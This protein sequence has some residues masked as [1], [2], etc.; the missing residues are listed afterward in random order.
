MSPSRIAD[1]VGRV[2]G[3][4]YR[5]ITPIGTGAS[6]HVFLADDA[7]LGRRV[8]VKC[9]HAALAGDEVFLRRFRAEAQAAAALNHPHIMAVIDWGEDGDGP[10]LVLEHL[11]GGSLRD[12]LDAGHRLS[13][14]QATAVGLEA[15][16]GLAYA[17]R[18]GLVHRDIKPANLLFDEESRLCV[19]DFGLA[20]ALAEAAWTE[21]V[22][23]LMGTARYSS[24]EAAQGHPVDGRADLYALGLVLIE[25]VTGKV[26]FSADTT[27]ATLMARIGTP[28]PVPDAM[29]PLGPVVATMTR[30]E[31]AERPEAPTLVAALESVARALPPPEA[32]PLAPPGPRQSAGAQV[33]STDLGRPAPPLI[34]LPGRDPDLRPD[35]RLEAPPGNGAGARPD[36]GP[37][38]AVRR[39]PETSGPD[40]DPSVPGPP[41]TGRARRRRWPWVVVAAVAALVLA[42]GGV[43]GYQV[44][45][46]PSYRVPQLRGLALARAETVV[47]RAPYRFHLVSHGRQYDPTVVAGAVV[48]QSPLAGSQLRRG[49]AVQVVVSRGPAPRA[50]P[51]LASL[52]QTTA[53][54]RLTAAGFSYQLSPAYSETVASGKVMA[55]APDHGPQPRGTRVTVTISQGPRPRTVP[56][57]SGGDTYGQAASQLQGLGL[58]PLRQGVYSDTVSAG[59]VVTTSPGPGLTVPR[60][61]DVTVSVS[62]GPHL[63][64]MPNLYGHPGSQ[65]VSSLQAAGLRVH[66]YGPD[67]SGPVIFTDPQPGSTVHYGATVSIYVL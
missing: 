30:P 19:A 14:A 40:L 64:T 48:S 23:A 65:A 11:G 20:R 37:G 61:A 51:S 54:G 31:F 67:P 29:G 15:A 36:A 8:A 46:V 47:G 3:G 43:A 33:D 58:V 66:V 16:K 59:Q 28:A 50:V 41:Y 27:I 49:D 9:L 24:P 22:G 62:L 34:V 39:D 55:W 45:G 4:R 2:L 18:R 13:P 56:D 52:D 60:G 12:M 7:T 17:H 6:G 53:V 32:L 25:A 63:V 42:A 38:H 5:L 1:Q 57:F 26:P 10:F 44:L 21:P 35:G